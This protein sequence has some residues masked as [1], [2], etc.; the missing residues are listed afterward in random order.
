M[1]HDL[2]LYIKQIMIMKKGEVIIFRD[3]Y[4]ISIHLQSDSLYPA[5]GIL[6]VGG[7]RLE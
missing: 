1:Q 7:L 3:S 2:T 5:Y 6:R 4:L